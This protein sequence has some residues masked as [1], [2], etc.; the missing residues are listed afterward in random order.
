MASRTIEVKLA[1]RMVGSSVA[2]FSEC[3][4][5]RYYLRRTLV[6]YDLFDECDHESMAVVMCNPS[7]ADEHRNDPT[8]RRMIGFANREKCRRLDVLNV[9]A[10]RATNPK[11]LRI[12]A[13]PVGP[14]NDEAIRSAVAEAGIL[15]AAWGSIPYAMPGGAKRIA[16]LVTLLRA[17]APVPIQCL[18]VSAEGHPRHPLYLRKDALLQEWR[19]A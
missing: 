10:Y 14:R 13:D 17:A 15:V 6:Q 7:T 4:M 1:R 19:Y 9:Y 5:W 11:A 16:E 2:I 12:A 8:V 18:G 3:R